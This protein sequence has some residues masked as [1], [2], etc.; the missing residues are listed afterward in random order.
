MR[1]ALQPRR[2]RALVRCSRN[3]K[4][5]PRRM[6][7]ASSR[8]RARYRPEN[9]VAYQP[10]KAA[11]VMAPAVIS[12]TSLPSQTGPMVPMAWPRP[13]S[14]RPTMP[15]SMPTP[16]SKP[17]NTRNPTHRKASTMNQKVVKSTSVS[18][19]ELQGRGV[20]IGLVR[21]RRRGERLAGEVGHQDGIDD[22]QRS[23]EQHQHGQADDEAGGVDRRGGPVAGELQSMHD[24]R[25][26]A[27]LGEQPAGRVHDERHRY[28]P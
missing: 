14:S 27:V 8:T 19:T 15:C 18:V 22:G 24:P 11:N 13:A 20:H 21:G 12:H 16:K 17:S 5:T 3:S 4:L 10:G 2:Q 6:S 28:R 26:P 1:V 7:A 25:L 23:V 9:M